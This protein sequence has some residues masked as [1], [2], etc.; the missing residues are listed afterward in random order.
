MSDIV[1]KDKNSGWLDT[2]AILLK[3]KEGDQLD[4][5]HF[6]GL[7]HDAIIKDLNTHYRDIKL[8][9]EDVA[10]LDR[11]FQ[12]YTSNVCPDVRRIDCEIDE[13]A[14]LNEVR[15]VHLDD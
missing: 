3:Q 9:R 11:W 6:V 8:T 10:I 1:N 5:G 15:I 12:A 7:S 2:L 13:I 14:S 4:S